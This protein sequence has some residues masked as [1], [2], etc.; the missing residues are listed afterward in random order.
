MLPNDVN[1]RIKVGRAMEESDEEMQEP[2]TRQMPSAGI[3][4]GVGMGSYEPSSSA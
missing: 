3:M 1:E 4:L 2:E